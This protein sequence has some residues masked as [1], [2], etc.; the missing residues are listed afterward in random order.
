MPIIRAFSPFAAPPTSEGAPNINEGD[1][2]T[3]DFGFDPEL[4]VPLL[5]PPQLEGELQAQE[6]IADSPRRTNTITQQGNR[7]GHRNLLKG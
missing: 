1:H 6:T 3:P 5:E 4:S 2:S 7:R